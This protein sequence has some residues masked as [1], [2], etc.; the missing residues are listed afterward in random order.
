MASRFLAACMAAAFGAFLIGAAHAQS[1]PSPAPVSHVSVQSLAPP[2]ATGPATLDPEK[3]TNAYLARVSGAA[4]ARSDSYFEGGYVLILV[5]A[6]YSVFVSA[7]LLWLGISA[8]MRNIA[9][10]ITRS[11][12]LQVPIYVVQFV[13]VTTVLTFPL[14]VYEGFMREHAYGLSNQNFLQWL[15]DFGT[16]FGVGILGAAIALTLLYAVIRATPRLWW[17]WGTLGASL[18]SQ[19]LSGLCSSAPCSTTTRSF[20]QGLCAK[21]S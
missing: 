3:A 12:F 16:G 7:I 19:R 17:A 21:K 1:N 8:G 6:L 11:R 18:H 13:I 14:N 15:G 4:R 5:D 9:Q 10:G 2:P 20:A